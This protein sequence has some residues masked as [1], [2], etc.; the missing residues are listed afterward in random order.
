ME[1]WKRILHHPMVEYI[2]LPFK[3]VKEGQKKRGGQTLL[4]IDKERE[5]LYPFVGEIEAP[6]KEKA[7]Y[8]LLFNAK[9]KLFKYRGYIVTIVGERQEERYQVCQLTCKYFYKERL[10]FVLFSLDG[11]KMAQ[12][13]IIIHPW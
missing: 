10:H 7:L 2:P 9:V 11:E 12:K 1:E 6:S 8:L 3:V 13:T 4:F 5:N